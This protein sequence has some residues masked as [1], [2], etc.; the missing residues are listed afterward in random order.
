MRTLCPNFD[1]EDALDTVLEVPIP[2]E[3]F[4]NMGNNAALRWQNMRAWMR[5]QRV[6]K[7][8]NSHLAN[9]TSND[10]FMLLLKLVGSPLIPFQV[11]A[12]HIMTLP[13]RDGSIVRNSFFHEVEKCISPKCIN[14]NKRN[15]KIYDEKSIESTTLLLS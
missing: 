11:Q 14:P 4:T 12:D 2:E 3:M 5:A 8:S 10:Q 7:L 13:I 9:G 15:P 6:D 1:K